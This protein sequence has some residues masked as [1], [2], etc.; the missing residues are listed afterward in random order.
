MFGKLNSTPKDRTTHRQNSGGHITNQF[1]WAD[2]SLGVLIIMSLLLNGEISTS[3][4]LAS[5]NVLT[6]VSEAP[7]RR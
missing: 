2:F 5:A 3:Q 7:T 4:K 1:T 6:N